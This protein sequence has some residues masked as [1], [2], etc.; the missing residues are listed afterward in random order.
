VGGEHGNDEELAIENK[1]RIE[2]HSELA[3][4]ALAD[5]NLAGQLHDGGPLE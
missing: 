5:D 3:Q 1:E 4:E 2:A